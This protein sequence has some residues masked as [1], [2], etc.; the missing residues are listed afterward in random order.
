MRTSLT[1]LAGHL[2]PAA[3]GGAAAAAVAAL[4]AA[5]DGAEGGGFEVTVPAGFVAPIQLR[6]GRLFSLDAELNTLFSS[7]G[8]RTWDAHGG[9]IVD[10]DGERGVPGLKSGSSPAQGM[11]WLC[12]L[13]SGAIGLVYWQRDATR[14]DSWLNAEDDGGS[15]ADWNQAV[16]RK[17]TDEAATWSPPVPIATAQTPAYPMFPV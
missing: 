10:A 13:R 17:S 5:E 15:E 12:R 9:P 14:L 6:D 8:G 4:A 2:T 16:F 1:R 7:G 11:C 3:G